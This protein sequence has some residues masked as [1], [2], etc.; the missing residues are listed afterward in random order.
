MI[1]IHSVDE[2]EIALL[3]STLFQL[4]QAIGSSIEID[5]DVWRYPW[6]RT[7]TE[8]ALLS[9]SANSTCTNDSSEPPPG[10]S[11]CELYKFSSLPATALS[12]SLRRKSINPVLELIFN[13]EYFISA[14]SLTPD[15]QQSMSAGEFP[16]HYLLL[17]EYQIIC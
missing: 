4:T 7:E 5:I 9:A 12:V 1:S 14:N 16:F 2:I 11:N 3:Y 15:A 8:V 10:L 13:D 17:C 6:N